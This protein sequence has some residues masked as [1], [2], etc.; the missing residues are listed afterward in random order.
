MKRKR[1]AVPGWKATEG[2]VD[3]CRGIRGDGSVGG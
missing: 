3:L 2:G 1:V